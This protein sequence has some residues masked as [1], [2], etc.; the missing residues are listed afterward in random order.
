V[1]KS[2]STKKKAT[3]KT[4]KPVA[5]AAN[6]KTSKPA[7]AEPAKAQEKPDKKA[8][9][10][11][12]CVFALRLTAEERAAIHKAAGPGKASKFARGLLVAAARNDDVALKAIIKHWDADSK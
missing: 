10:G 6:A 3:A 11:E 4:E 2:K 12:L 9:R 7:A 8:A 5:A 1:K